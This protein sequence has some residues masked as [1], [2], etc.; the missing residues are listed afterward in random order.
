MLE[1]LA[2]RGVDLSKTTQLGG[3][4]APRSYSN[5][6]GPNVGL[7]IMSALI[8][9]VQVRCVTAGCVNYTCVNM[10]FGLIA[11]RLWPVLMAQRT[12][13]PA[14]GSWWWRPSRLQETSLPFLPLGVSK[15]LPS[16][17]VMEATKLQTIHKDNGSVHGV[18]LRTSDGG[19]QMLT[20]GAVVL[21]TGGFGANKTLLQVCG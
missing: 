11:C 12:R 19:T 16:V 5:A 21:A 14:V 20:C 4:S 7:A 17:R 15:G 18:T 8:K 2:A 10:S 13:M 3:H 9:V 1:F 6:V